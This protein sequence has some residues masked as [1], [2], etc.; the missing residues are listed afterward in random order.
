MSGALPPPA[1]AAAA[2]PARSGGGSG[3]GLVGS[4]SASTEA[5]RGIVC[6]FVYGATSPL[7]GHP[8][9]SV[10]TRMQADARF[11]STSALQTFRAILAGEGVRGLYRGLLP[12]LL[13]SSVF[14][15]VQ[16]SVYAFAMSAARESPLLSTEVPGSGGLQLRVLAAGLAS[17]AARALLETPLELVKVRRQMG[18]GSWL[19]AA[20][21]EEALRDPLRELR[22]LYRGFGVTFLRTWGLMG[23]FFVLVDTLERKHAD[24]LAVPVLGPWMKGGV[25]TVVAWALVWPFETLKNQMQAARGAE[26]G[27]RARARA[28]VAERG[29]LGLYRG[30]GPGLTRAFVANGASM[31]ALSHCQRCFDEG[32]LIL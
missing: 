15:S 4:G 28:V 29:V 24:L 5:L 26:Q 3:G 23:T 8:I 16:F 12:P 20:S 31:V 2:A 30:I 13:G 6:G 32:R 22:G 7:V 9:D 11:A 27:W 25:C 19:V 18:G 10:K 21:A 1:A 14:R 17:S